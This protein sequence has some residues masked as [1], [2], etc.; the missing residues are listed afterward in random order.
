MD[1]TISLPDVSIVS[2]QADQSRPKRAQENVLTI[3]DVSIVS[4]Q[5]DQ[6]RLRQNL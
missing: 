2:I 4:I 5:A 6:S 1:T 3:E